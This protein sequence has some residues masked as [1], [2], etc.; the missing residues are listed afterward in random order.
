[1]ENIDKIQDESTL[2][3]TDII[4]L[5]QRHNPEQSVADIALTKVLAAMYSTLPEDVADSLIKLHS[6][7]LRCSVLEIRMA[8]RDNLN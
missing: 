1:M 4:H 7:N 6:K 8:Q 2:L 3:A 5:L